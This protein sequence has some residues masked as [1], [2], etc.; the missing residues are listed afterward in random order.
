MIAVG[1]C[2]AVALPAFADG[3]PSSSPSSATP[4]SYVLAVSVTPHEVDAGESATVTATVTRSSG[5][6]SDVRV[7]LSTGAAHVDFEPISCSGRAVPLPS[8]HGCDLDAVA[9]DSASAVQSFTLP[10]AYVKKKT[11]VTLNVSLVKDG[12]EIRPGKATVVFDPKPSP[13]PSSPK[14]TKP[15]PS[16]PGKLTE[17]PATPKPTSS[18]PSPTRSSNGGGSGTGSGSGGGTGGNNTSAS[19]NGGNYTPP[20]TNGSFDSSKNPQVALPP[21]TGNAP[22]PSVASPDAP[23]ATPQSTLRAN[24][25]P[26]AQEMTFQRVASTQIAWLA[27]LLV[28]CSLLLTQLRLGRR[29]VAAS[30]PAASKRARG[31]HRRPRNGAHS[32]K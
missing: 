7:L 21:I 12:K 24:K 27:A 30:A 14:P 15:S 1:A 5:D 17:P 4:T 8:T 28:A 19:G 2:A 26:V 22:S 29:P 9:G 13:S 23:S 3:T 6:F 25:H 31:A 16:D 10:P 18:S 20:N 11:A 32:K